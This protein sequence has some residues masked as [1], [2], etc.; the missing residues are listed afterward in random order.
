MYLDVHG[1]LLRLTC[2]S[3]DSRDIGV[4]QTPS[5]SQCSGAAANFLC[6]FGEFLDLCNLGFADICVQLITESF[7][8]W[9]VFHCE[10]GIVRNT[11][12]VL[13]G[14]ET[15]CEGRPNCGAVMVKLVQGSIFLLETIASEEIVLWLVSNGSNQ[16][17]LGGHVVSMLYLL[18]FFESRT[19]LDL[20]GG[21]FRSSPVECLSGLNEMSEPTN[22][23]LHWSRLIRT[24]CHNNIHIIQLKSFKRVIHSLNQMLSTQSNFIRRILLNQ[25]HDLREMTNPSPEQFG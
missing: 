23:F 22:D 20:K 21:P 10:T 1:D 19:T 11:V 9:I 6:K 4:L 3:N 8:E 5:Q 14:Q 25:S 18:A 16:I 24:M 13:A 7:H 12:V 17:V 2:T 15:T